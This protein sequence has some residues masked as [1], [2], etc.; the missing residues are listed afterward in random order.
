MKTNI[1]FDQLIAMLFDQS[2]NIAKLG[3]GKSKIHCQSN[4][5]LAKT[6]PHNRRAPHGYE[7]VRDFRGCK[8]ENDTAQLVR[9]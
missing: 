1:G 9:Q 4:P 5:V 3:F 8:S 6:S 7:A 2:L